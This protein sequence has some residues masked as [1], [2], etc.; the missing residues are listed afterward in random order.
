[1]QLVLSG[2]PQTIQVPDVVG[3]TLGQARQVL[4]QLGLTVGDVTTPSG[5]SPG[6][7]DI[8]SS[9]SPAAGAQVVGGS[10]IALKVGSE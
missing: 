4:Q 7:G 10:R 1:V 9:Q 6:G 3:R 8:V 2:G 5:G